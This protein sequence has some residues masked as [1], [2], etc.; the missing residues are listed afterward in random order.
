M[1]SMSKK[2]KR[3][4]LGESNPGPP[5]PEAGIMPLD[6]A[7]VTCGRKKHIYIHV[8]YKVCSSVFVISSKEKILANLRDNV[9]IYSYTVL[10]SGIHICVVCD[11]VA[12]SLIE[13]AV[14]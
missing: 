2:Q 14:L 4:P 6:Q 1:L 7:D 10:L 8:N 11:V 3:G 12:V 13:S 9:N 5:A